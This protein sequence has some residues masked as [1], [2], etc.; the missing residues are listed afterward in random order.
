LRAA[1]EAA[2][3]APPAPDPPRAVDVVLDAPALRLTEGQEAAAATLRRAL[4]LILAT[5][6]DAGKVRVGRRLRQASGRAGQ[7]VALELWDDESWHAI[8]ASHVQF[9]RAAGAL[10]HLQWARHVLARS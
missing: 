7:L 5:G 9:A 1:A 3:A 8:A 2:R 10:T 4:Q 6:D